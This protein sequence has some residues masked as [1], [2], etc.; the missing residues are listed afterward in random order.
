MKKK[1]KGLLG[2]MLEK[3]GKTEQIKD[4]EGLWTIKAV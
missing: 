3:S 1:I 4:N 2:E